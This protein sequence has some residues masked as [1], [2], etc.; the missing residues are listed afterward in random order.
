M[1]E[2]RIN[3]INTQQ[4]RIINEVVAALNESH[5]SFYYLSTIEVAAEIK[6]YFHTAS[7]LSVEDFELVD[8]LSRRDIQILLSL[9][10][11]KAT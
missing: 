10:E 8:K 1:E 3:L 9:H 6:K 7:R 4:K 2:K 11:R 5:P